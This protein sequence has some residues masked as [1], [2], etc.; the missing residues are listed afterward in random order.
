MCVYMEMHMFNYADLD[1]FCMMSR[2]RERERGGEQDIS[3]CQLKVME[4]EHAVR[5]GKL[6]LA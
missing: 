6:T 2:S 5:H 3:Q 4:S 1:Q